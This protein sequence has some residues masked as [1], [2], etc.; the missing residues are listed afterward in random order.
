MLDIDKKV[1]VLVLTDESGALFPLTQALRESPFQVHAF[2]K[3]EE[4]IQFLEREHPPLIVSGES[5]LSFLHKVKVTAPQSVCIFL[6][7]DHHLESIKKAINQ[8]DVYRVVSLD[9][10]YDLQHVLEESWDYYCLLQENKR[11]I[12]KAQKQSQELEVAIQ[13]LEKSI[14][15]RTKILQ[16]SRL[17]VSQTQAELEHVNKFMKNISMA[18]TVEEMATWIKR[19]LKKI[20]DFDDFVVILNERKPQSMKGGNQFTVAI[21]LIYENHFLGHLYLKGRDEGLIKEAQQY[22]GFLQ[23]L[24]HAMAMTIDRIQFFEKASRNKKAW[25]A[26]F[27]AI[28]DPVSILGPHYEV[29]RANTAYSKV[30]DV[31]LPQL[32]GRKCYEVFENGS[33]FCNGCYMQEAFHAN[34]PIV[35]DISSLKQKRKY[36]ATSYPVYEKDGGVKFIVQYYKDL[37]KEPNYKDHLIRSEKTAELGVLAGSIAHEINNPLAGILAF[38]QI[39]KSE[40]TAKDFLLKDIL[41]IEE[42]TLRCKKIIDNLLNFA[43]QSQEEKNTLHQVEDILDMSVSLI[44]HQVKHYNIQFTK[45]YFSGSLSVSGNFNQLWQAVVNILENAIEAVLEKK[46]GLKRISVIVK[47]TRGFVKISIVNNGKI[48]PQKELKKIFHPLYTTKDPQKNPGLG[49]SMSQSI[50]EDH[51]GFLQVHV[52]S[53]GMTEFSI[54]LPLFR[55]S[56]SKLHA[57]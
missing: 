34:Q 9:V 20:I 38:S 23:Q 53:S 15:E 33:T 1:D 27:D 19:E 48:I 42:A 52:T 18:M 10:Y 32:I 57:K 11:L 39:V 50:V 36:K 56:S 7:E 35:S 24:S 46:K 25:E 55:R 3:E 22:L 8:G 45:K 12:E 21:P 43:R 47:K 28:V 6:S 51:G 26:T 49:L 44:E 29:K 2:E 17:E 31:K 13:S 16:E 37:T 14:E 40:L 5:F 30:C 41:D 54:F 4:A